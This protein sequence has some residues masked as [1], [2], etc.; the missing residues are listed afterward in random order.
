MRLLIELGVRALDFIF[1]AGLIGTVVVL[2]MTGIED[3]M[4]IFGRTP[5]EPRSRA[6]RAAHQSTAT[7]ANIL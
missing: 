5:E 1:A 3:T 2:I 6:Y 7:P 4:T